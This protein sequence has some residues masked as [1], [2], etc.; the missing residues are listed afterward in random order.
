MM[1]E[2]DDSVVL[3]ARKTLENNTRIFKQ[4]GTLTQAGYDVTLIGIKPDYLPEEEEQEGYDIVRVGTFSPNLGWIRDVQERLFLLYP[5]YIVLKWL[6]LKLT[7]AGRITVRITHRYATHLYRWLSTA[8]PNRLT[9]TVSVIRGLVYRYLRIARIKWLIKSRII[10][11]RARWKGPGLDTSSGESRLRRFLKQVRY[12]PTKAVKHVVWWPFSHIRWLIMSCNYYIKSYRAMEAQ[13]LKPD[14][15]HANDLNTLFVAIVAARHYDVPVVYDAQELY[16]EIHTLPLWYRHLLRLQEHVLIRFT[17]RVTTV[18]PFIAE[19]ME[20]RYER[21]IDEVILNCPPFDPVEDVEARPGQTVCEKFDIDPNVPVILYSGGLSTQRGLE[22]LVM[23][24]A[25]VPDVVLVI[26]GE[27]PLREDLE[28]I[29]ARSGI[30]ERVYFS[31]FVPHEEVPTFIASADIGVVPYERV[32][33]NHFLCSP[34]KLFHY[35]MAEV[36]VVGSEYPFL[37]HVINDNAIGDTFDPKDKT[38]MTAAIKDMVKNPDRFERHRKNVAEAK[39]KYTWENESKKFLAQ[40]ERVTGNT[41]GS[42]SRGS[43]SRK[44]THSM[45]D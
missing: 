8:V 35:I 18:N 42:T 36:V 1:S 4:A 22:N 32:G 7:T 44:A 33:T 31:E 3:F 11:L 41:D 6:L 24:M 21:E 28:A 43:K 14:V 16:T 15:I 2:D 37:S 30:S 38:S 5:F 13:G 19:V 20:K 45:P 29:A 12:N 23:A 26:L 9:W 40:Y 25:D 10:R 27:G 34:S 17:D 39:H